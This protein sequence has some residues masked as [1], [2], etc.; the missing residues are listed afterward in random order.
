[1]ANDNK[2]NED[3]DALKSLEF[4]ES[5]IILEDTLEELNNL[6]S[7][8][9]ATRNFLASKGLKKVAELDKDGMRELTE[10]LKLTLCKAMEKMFL[11][12][13]K[14]QSR[15][16]L[17]EEDLLELNGVFAKIMSSFNV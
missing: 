1:M 17:S 14:A 3:I 8:F 10:H 7:F 11:A 5:K 15:E 12:E 9:P 4:L 16:E 2:G 13:H 6:N